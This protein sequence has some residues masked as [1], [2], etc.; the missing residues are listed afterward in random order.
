MTSATSLSDR[1]FAW[2][3]RAGALAISAYW[4]DFF[5]RGDVRTSDEAAYVDVERAFLLADAFLVT[6]GLGAAHYLSRGRPEAVPLGIAT[7]SAL[8]FLGLMDLAYDL[9]QGKFSDRTPGM[10][11]EAA[12]VATSLTLGPYTMIRTW[13]ARS[14]LGLA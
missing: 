4:V 1:A 13:R 12:I 6:A 11:T 14:R 9:Q 3:L 8:T 2:V 10:A 7:G 5:T